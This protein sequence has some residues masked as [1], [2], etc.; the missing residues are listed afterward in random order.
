MRVIYF[1][2]QYGWPDGAATAQILCDAL[3]AVPPSVRVV[4]IQSHG[5]YSLMDQGSEAPPVE[6]RR[7]WAP[8]VTNRRTSGKLLAF[9]AFY[10]QAFVVLST[11]PRGSD[12]VVMTTPPFLNWLGSASKVLRGGRLVSWEM[13]VYPEILFANG[14]VAKGG[15]V[16]RVLSG[17][18]RWARRRTDASL[19]LGPCMG[20]MLND[21]AG[22]PFRVVEVQNW[23]DG[24]AL[25]PVRVPGS[26]RLLTLLYSGNLGVAH[27]IET[28]VGAI[29]RLS[30]D[31][32][33]FVFSGGGVK[34]TTVRALESDYVSFRSSCRYEELNALLNEADIGVVTQTYESVGCVVPSKLYG[35]MAAGRPILF[36]GPKESTVAKV[37]GQA[38]C[39]WQVD[40]RDVDGLLE[41]L[42]RLSRDRELVREAGRRSRLAFEQCYERSIGVKRFW[43]SLLQAGQLPGYSLIE[44]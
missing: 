2:N 43:D 3:R 37:I 25:F 33:R 19:V 32:V 18:T 27:E 38:D 8:A 31:T 15:P 4:L 5:R 16:G 7:L 11:R 14:L 44:R 26:C 34:M 24:S 10:L 9:L 17:L 39:G 36:I 21:S 12:V 30:V 40:V 20:E 22:G 29:T 35:L 42:A 28:L 41:L 13:D 6:I 1:V 23:A